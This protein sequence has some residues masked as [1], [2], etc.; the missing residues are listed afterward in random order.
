MTIYCEN[1]AKVLEHNKRTD[2][3]YKLGFTQFMDLKS[4]EFSLIMLRSKYPKISIE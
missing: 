4:E 1:R 3:S 2:S